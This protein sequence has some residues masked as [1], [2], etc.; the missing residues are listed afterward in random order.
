[1]DAGNGV[2]AGACKEPFPGF[3]AHTAGVLLPINSTQAP[4]SV[5]C[6]RAGPSPY[7]PGTMSQDYV[8]L[9]VPPRPLKSPCARCGDEV[10]GDPK[11]Q[12]WRTNQ[13]PPKTPPG[14]DNNNNNN[15]P[16]A[17][18]T[19]TL[20]PAAE[21]QPAE[22]DGGDCGDAPTAPSSGRPSK[23]EAEKLLRGTT[24]TT[25]APSTG[26]ERA[27]CL[28]RKRALAGGAAAGEGEGEGA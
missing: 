9:L 27:P 10:A 23:A 19:E 13:T 20:P 28:Q 5:P 22:D 26:R 14:A 17:N 25:A 4:G 11:D 21:P 3:L 15:K 8:A 2:C 1:M 16:P 24:T 7:E 12:F 6:Y 18:G